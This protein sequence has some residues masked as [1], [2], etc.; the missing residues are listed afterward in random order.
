MA[1]GGGGGGGSGGIRAGRAFVEMSLRDEKF[2]GQLAEVQLRVAAAGKTIAAS[3]LG[4]AKAFDGF[5]NKLR[6]LTGQIGKLGGLG[7]F[8]GIG[9]AAGTFV[10][11]ANAVATIAANVGALNRKLEESA[12]LSEKFT[13]SFGPLAFADKG[14]TGALALPAIPGQANALAGL[15]KGLE[16]N[17]AGLEGRLNT[18]QAKFDELNTFIA[19]QA[20]AVPG[21]PGTAQQVKFDEAKR[22]LD[23]TRKAYEDT[24]KAIAKVKGELARVN[25]ILTASF[26]QLNDAMVDEAKNLGKSAEEIAIA[27]LAGQGLSEEKHRDLELTRKGLEGLRNEQALLSLT[28]QLKREAEDFGK[29]SEERAIRELERKTFLKPADLAEARAA[30]A[31]LSRLR[32]RPAANFAGLGRFGGLVSA[33]NPERQLSKQMAATRGAFSGF[34]SLE[35]VF[36]GAG[37]DMT[38]ELK[39]ANRIAAEQLDAIKDV[40]KGIAGLQLSW[41][42]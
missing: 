41:G 23:D 4:A 8:L 15:L 14:I 27:K 29:T 22:N 13:A 17:R 37:K 9:G 1:T 35:G 30:A 26:N 42:A 25:A 40:T 20:R 36:G 2:A 21:L 16:A 3:G 12:R 38:H 32:A 5:G 7:E 19:D 34:G 18:A 24:G 39:R 33:V 6:A 31:E 28:A 10:V 11:A